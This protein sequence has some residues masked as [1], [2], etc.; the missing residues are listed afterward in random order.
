MLSFSFRYEILLFYFCNSWLFCFFF[1]SSL[2]ILIF[3]KLFL[4]FSQAVFELKLIPSLV[5][6]AFFFCLFQT[7]LSSA[8]SSMLFIILI[9]DGVLAKITF[10]GPCLTYLQMIIEHF[11]RD[12]KFTILTY[13]W[14]HRT[15]QEMRRNII[16]LEFK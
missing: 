4:K 13:L 8:N 6:S 12:I 10:L 2:F 3:V 1:K 7:H 9:R 11:D 16:F 5:S 15:D 14:F